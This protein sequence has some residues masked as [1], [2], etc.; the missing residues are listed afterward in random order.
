[1]DTAAK[2]EKLIENVSA[3]QKKFEEFSQT[4]VDS[5]VRAIGKAVYDNAELLARMA[6]D[7]TGMGRYEDKVQKNKSK[8]KI[9]WYKL[10]NVK[11]RGI[12]NR[13]DELGLVE[14]VRFSHK[15]HKKEVID[16]TS[17]F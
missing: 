4:Q 5:A 10:K 9:T 11:S 2:V 6:V 8:P 14:T 17:F 1:M 13:R 7:E 16:E 15:F 12:I 3:A